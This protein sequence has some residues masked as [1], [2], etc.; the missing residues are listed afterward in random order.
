MRENKLSEIL[1][2]ND[3]SAGQRCGGAAGCC[4]LHRD[5]GAKRS[6]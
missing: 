6:V 3:R 4:K 1:R 5:R 2:R